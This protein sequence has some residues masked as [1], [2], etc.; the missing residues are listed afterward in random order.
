VGVDLIVPKPF[1][2]ATLRK[3]VEEATVNC[4]N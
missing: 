3:A 2:Q 4:L 1:T